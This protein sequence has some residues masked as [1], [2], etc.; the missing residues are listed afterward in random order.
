MKCPIW[1]AFL[2]PVAI[3]NGQMTSEQVKTVSDLKAAAQQGDVMVQFSLGEAY[4]AGLPSL[5]IDKDPAEAV[6]WY[7]EAADNHWCEAMNMLA[8][9][10]DRGKEI[11]K[12]EELSLK[13]TRQAAELG[14]QEAQAHLASYYKKGYGGLK[15]DL[16]KSITWSYI[17][18]A[19]AFKNE[20]GT[21]LPGISMPDLIQQIKAAADGGMPEAEY[22]RG[23]MFEQGDDGKVDFSLAL[24]WYLKAADQDFPPAEY[25]AAWMLYHGKGVPLDTARACSYFSKSAAH[26]NIAAA[27]YLKNVGAAAPTPPSPPK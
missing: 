8:R 16:V 14:S 21:V 19:S 25:Q 27:F 11:P 22:A 26:G 10:Y 5:H 18:T 1:I 12:D 20:G 17:A 13:W 15:P 23:L 9:L 4:L 2:L 6:K 24:Q 3:A 7:T